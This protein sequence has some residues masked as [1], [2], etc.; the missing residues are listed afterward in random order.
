M[1]LLIH[2]QL[3]NTSPIKGT[4]PLKAPATRPSTRVVTFSISQDE[5]NEQMLSIVGGK[6]CEFF[7]FLPCFDHLS[8]SAVEKL[9]KPQLHTSTLPAR[10]CRFLSQ[11]QYLSKSRAFKRDTSPRSSSQTNTQDNGFESLRG[12]HQS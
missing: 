1:T 11:F 8:V 5:G 6:K 3:D 10:G 12:F 9:V 4:L 7:F 2:S